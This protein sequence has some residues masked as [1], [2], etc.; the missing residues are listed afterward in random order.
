MTLIKNFDFVFEFRIQPSSLA[1]QITLRHQHKAS[2]F[3]I[4]DSG[5]KS[6]FIP[7]LVTRPI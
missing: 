3:P 1:N 2:P 7:S 4:A 5:R 6:G